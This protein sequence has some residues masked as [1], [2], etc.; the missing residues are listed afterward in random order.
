M[1]VL[2]IVSDQGSVGDSSLSFWL[3]TLHASMQGL[4]IWSTELRQFLQEGIPSGC[5]QPCFGCQSDS[6]MNL[7]GRRQC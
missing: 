3:V 1:N 6:W 7:D 5:L 4:T 2:A